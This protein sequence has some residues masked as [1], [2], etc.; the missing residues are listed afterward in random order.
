MSSR[1]LHHSQHTLVGG[2]IG[3][4]G[5]VA[6]GVVGN[7]VLGLPVS[8]PTVVSIRHVHAAD[9]EVLPV[10]HRYHHVLRVPSEHRRRKIIER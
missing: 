3:A 2:G 4:D 10:L 7:R 8:C 6:L 5:E 1:Y 9:L